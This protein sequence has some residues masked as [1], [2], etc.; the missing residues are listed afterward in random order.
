VLD[1]L[2][3][4]QHFHGV[5][6]KPGKPFGYWSNESCGVF[7][8]PGNPLS[9][10]VGLHRYVLPALFQAMGASDTTLPKVTLKTDAPAHPKLTLF[11]P[12][13]I[14]EAGTASPRPANNSG[15]FV[16][17]LATDGF[18]ELPS[19][20]TGKAAAGTLAYFIKWH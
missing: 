11:L 19:N 17:I 5:A 1:E 7:A 15:D 4:T 14:E 10:L 9:V 16:S 3:L 20:K 18:I 6:Q 13:S 8:L 2:G 12:I